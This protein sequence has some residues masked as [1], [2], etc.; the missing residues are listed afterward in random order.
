M[1]VIVHLHQRN[2]GDSPGIAMFPANKGWF[3]C[4]SPMTFLTQQNNKKMYGSK[5]RNG[6]FHHFKK[7][8]KQNL[9]PRLWGL[10]P[11]SPTDFQISTKM[12]KKIPGV[13]VI[14]AALSGNSYESTLYGASWWNLNVF[15]VGSL[16]LHIQIEKM[17]QSSCDTDCKRI[18]DTFAW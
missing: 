5:W 17:I 8:T 1:S 6:G 15:D 9:W 7:T 14:V 18:V 16:S 11:F 10:E 3:I 4:D 13:D 12:W 2:L